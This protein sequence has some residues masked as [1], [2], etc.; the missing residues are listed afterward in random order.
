MTPAV[1]LRIIRL[2]AEV[3]EGN[4]PGPGDLARELV[5]IGLEL[6][7]ADELREHLDA[8]DQARIETAIDV[9]EDAKVGRP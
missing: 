3:L 9:L 8:A 7:P 2:G 6:V 1:V 4:I 5:G